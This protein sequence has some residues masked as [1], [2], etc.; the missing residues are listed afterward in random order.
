MASAAGLTLIEGILPLKM[1]FLTEELRTV[2]IEHEWM[3]TNIPREA[4]MHLPVCDDPA[5]KELLVYVIH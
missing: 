4:K 2:K 1:S 5:N 3:E